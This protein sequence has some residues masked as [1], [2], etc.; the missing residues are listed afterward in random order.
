MADARLAA[1]GDLAD[2]VQLLREQVRTGQLGKEQLQ[3]AAYCGDEAA[4]LVIPD[5]DRPGQCWEGPGIHGWEEGEPKDLAQWIASLGSILERQAIV[6]AV[7]AVARRALPGWEAKGGP[8][9]PRSA[10]EFA[11]DWAVCPCDQHAGHYKDADLALS[12]WSNI[13]RSLLLRAIRLDFLCTELRQ[14]PFDLISSS[15]M[16][17]SVQAEVIPWALGERDP[18]RDRRL[19]QS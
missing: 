4:L 11:E 16:Y 12:R 18:V 17:Q 3:V 13:A 9:G 5:E 10:I 2:K 19:R 15:A 1:T 7:I 14:L 6:R 8:K